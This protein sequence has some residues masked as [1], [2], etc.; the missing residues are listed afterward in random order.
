MK[1]QD[2]ETNRNLAIESARTFSAGRVARA[3]R[4]VL[5]LLL[6]GMPLYA[7]SNA[8]QLKAA[9]KEAATTHKLAPALSFEQSAGQ[10]IA[11]GRRG[12]LILEK[13][14]ARFALAHKSASGQ[15][16]APLAHLEF[17]GA[18]AKSAISGEQELPGKVYHVRD[19]KG[20]LTA[21]STFR[22]VRY[23]RLYR[24]IDAVF[25]GNERE[26]E[27]DFMV[28]PRADADAV[29]LGFSGARR[30]RLT[31]GGDV[32]I[33]V[34][35]DTV[36]LRKPT[37]YQQQRRG[38]RKEIAG[39]Y[40]IGGRDKNEISIHL[41][42]Y[43]HS[44]PL[45]IDPSFTF[46]SPQA[47]EGIFAFESN[48]KG[49][50]FILGETLDQANFPTTLVQP[51]P[52]QQFAQSCFLT[53][54]NSSLTGAVYSIIFDETGCGNPLAVSPS[55]VAYL[56]GSVF[57]N[58]PNG[59]VSVGLVVSVDD[60]SGTPQINSFPSINYDAVSALAVNTSG[61][62]FVFG[63]CRLV[64]PG[65]PPL[66]L[67]G[68]NTQPLPAHDIFPDGCTG[69]ETDSN[70]FREPLL[71]VFDP[72]GNL[73]YAS[74]LSPQEQFFSPDFYSMTADDA[75]R[76]YIL[77]YTTTP[78]TV[79]PDAY[80]SQ[81]ATT[82][83]HLTVVDTTTTGAASLA[84]SSYLWQIFGQPLGLAVRTGPD[85]SAYLAL[86][87]AGFGDYPYTP[88]TPPYQPFAFDGDS[89]SF[90]AVEL[91]RF[92]LGSTGTPNQLKYAL[93][94]DPRVELNGPGAS[95]TAGRWLSGLRLLPSGTIAVN[96]AVD[97]NSDGSFDT[98]AVDIF[99]PSAQLRAPLIVNQLWNT[100][101][102]PLNAGQI[103]AD[104]TGNLYLA[105]TVIN[106]P[107]TTAD[108]EVDLFAN[109]DPGSNT[110]PVVQVPADF[111]VPSTTN[112]GVIVT[113]DT[114]GFDAEDGVLPVSCNPGS[115]TIFFPIGA[116]TVTCTATDSGGLS[117]SASFTVT[118]TPPPVN[119]PPG[120]NVVVE[121]ID[122]ARNNIFVTVYQPITLTFGQMNT[123]G[124]TSLKTRLDLNPPPPCADATSC[125]Q[126][127]S[128]PTYFDLTTQAVFDAS[129]GIDMC[130][131]IRGMSLADPNSI[132][133][134]Q[135]QGQNWSKLNTD[136][137][138]GV[139]ACTHMSSLGTFAIF[140][141][142]VPETAI[143]TIAGT[144]VPRGS[145]DG[146][147]G[148]PNDNAN[149]GGP[150]TSAAVTP[151]TGTLDRARNV[152]YVSDISVFPDPSGVA[153]RVRQID[154][155]T[156][157]IS[158]VSG[159]E[160]NSFDISGMA[161]DS[162]GNLYFSDGGGCDIRK[163]DFSTGAVTV[164]AGTGVCGFSGDGSPA[165]QGQINPFNGQLAIDSNDNLFLADSGNSRIRRV[166]A[167]TGLIS[168]FAGDGTARVVVSGTNPTQN[169]IGAVTGLA[170]D[171]AGNVLIAT[172]LE[173]LSIPPEGSVINILAGCQSNCTGLPFDG[174]GRA[175]SDLNTTILHG[176]YLSIGNDGAIL[177]TAQS[178]LRIRRIDPGS[179]GILTG[180]PDE[181]IWTVAGYFY[182]ITNGIGIFNGDTFSTQSTLA[183]P[184]LALEDAQGNLLIL[185][186]NNNRI[187]KTG[188]SPKLPGG[189]PAG[190]GGGADL[191]VSATS[192]PDTVNTGDTITYGPI[193]VFN[194]G[195]QDASGA[196]LT[197]ALPAEVGFSTV[198][199]EVGSC[200]A[201][202][203][204]S[205]GTVLCD[206][207]TL[208]NG[209]TPR[210]T[211]TVT[212]QQA[213]ASRATVSVSSSVPDPNPANN[214]ATLSTTVNQA[215]IDD[216]ETIT[217]TDTV[218]LLPSAVIPVAE[219]ITVTDASPILL[220]SA[221]IADPES[222]T[223]TDAPSVVPQPIGVIVPVGAPVVVRLVDANNNPVP[224]EL[225]FPAVSQQGMAQ[226]NVVIPIPA[227][228]RGFKFRGPVFDITTTAVYTGPV[229]V[230][231]LGN[232]FLT[233]DQLWHA[234]ALIGSTVNNS[235]RVCATVT[236]L[237]P[238]GVVE[239]SYQI[240]LLYDQNVT[241]K[242]GSAYPIKLQLC[243]A[244]G[245]NLSS[246]SITVHAI[247]VTQ[248][249]S[250]TPVTL[251]DTGNANPDL[252]FRYDSTLAGY[253][254]NLS[255]KGYATGTYRLDFI[256]GGDPATHSALFAVK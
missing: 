89:G 190:Q 251:D 111:S 21:N 255:T 32:A 55:G 160:E 170:I 211:V 135:A 30:I 88:P 48:A 161:L 252:D 208:G 230:C 158:A 178:D 152:L 120:A 219:N 113:Y 60:S 24:G 63:S 26:L 62:V 155:N 40:A 242:S 28:A 100:S 44:L 246:S 35:D 203:V 175:L 147:G 141:P 184:G 177:L 104:S 186:S 181:I 127:G 187:R 101:A 43:D 248:I 159:T 5:T 215:P 41:G 189:H 125:L 87:A 201:P 31:D 91:A 86:S 34:V 7:Q 27:F 102:A 202:A 99:Y 200:T 162:A 106:A 64:Q 209:A 212:A 223:V 245:G 130:I 239:P 121:P 199:T 51:G 116:T 213:G 78:I 4:I 29:R 76:A 108:V 1:I 146:P 256:A 137:T 82:C 109:A 50:T 132:A 47:D 214:S 33:D 185:D 75:G 139:K 122:E 225:T 234:G 174:D 70:V 204:G 171:K 85:G 56:T 18:N 94:F 129:A 227:P 157:I 37:I 90:D 218:L 165:V 180:Q 253:I 53:K 217:V 66:Q 54:L 17:A 14:G 243:D 105:R 119:T 117:A 58:T 238:F 167:V 193:T 80:Q 128:P 11:R 65:D 103:A 74:L 235:G 136:V 192:S 61:S 179:D 115:G 71:T 73:L 231:F 138:S 149:D 188:Y 142:V 216:P 67:N 226:A 169:G 2:K 144:G 221:M 110:P 228:P 45:V 176:N 206:L 84:Y 59:L 210:V 166:D 250:N 224:I 148:N 156:G 133:I 52:L 57:N 42:P 222:I 168:T 131:D 9:P 183:A 207:G 114:S 98:D 39:A 22:R 68:F 36:L 164:I 95:A 25:Y 232:G 140:Y 254:F 191:S 237:S 151:I 172:T 79:T 123:G 97:V 163:K 112:A 145:I 182:P 13:N 247:G 93:L 229:T 3:M 81:C 173:L 143:R 69:S 124:F 16:R 126:A 194:D 220:P 20:P 77:G 244:D 154:L 236:S 233:Q 205:S 107:S 92:T 96:T 240:C 46:G 38:V 241:K 49:E 196:K 6:F 12:S 10:F 15:V 19:F 195:P 23:S 8:A 118:V 72:Q 198:T 153:S 150:A 134:Y 197:V 83:P 249:S